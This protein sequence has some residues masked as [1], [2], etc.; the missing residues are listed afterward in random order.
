[1]TVIA[2]DAM[3]GDLGATATIPAVVDLLSGSPDVHILLFGDEADLREQLRDRSGNVPSERLQLID[4]PQRVESG[5]RPARAL[6][7]KRESSMWRALAAVADGRASACVSA[8]ETGTLMAMGTAVLGT[9]PGIERPAICTAL[10]TV[11]GRVCLLDLGANVDCDGTTLH[12]FARMGVA[13]LQVAE[14]LR[15]P[16]VALLNIGAEAGKGN[17]AVK[18]AAELLAADATINYI[19]FVEGDGL[20]RG[21]ADLVVC[22][23]FVGNVA[24]KAIE[25]TAQLLVEQLRATGR[26]RSAWRSWVARPLFKSALGFLDPGQYNGASMLGLRGVVVKSH[27]GADSAGFGHALTVALAEARGGMPD[28]IAARLA[29]LTSGPV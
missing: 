25:G 3:G 27:G 22:D 13:R 23:G 20:L 29:A 21:Q 12:Q 11:A 8:G 26:G 18:A 16:R 4:C 10:P 17:R 9:L 2:V 15:A 6:R 24:L 28:R 1:L 7:H 14:R 5:D 19:G